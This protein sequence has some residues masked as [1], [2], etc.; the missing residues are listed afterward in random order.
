MH[1]RHTGICILVCDSIDEST[2][3]QILKMNNIYRLIIELTLSVL[4]LSMV[5]RLFPLIN[6]FIYLLAA[7]AENN[8][9]VVVKV[10]FEVTGVQSLCFTTR[11]LL[12]YAFPYFVPVSYDIVCIVLG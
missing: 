3:I 9:R 10:S 1:Q 4:C 2:T 7:V 5:R 6:L 12:G 8:I 11:V